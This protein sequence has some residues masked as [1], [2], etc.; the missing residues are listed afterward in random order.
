MPLFLSEYF[1]N[2]RCPKERPLKASEQF[3]RPTHVFQSHVLDCFHSEDVPCNRAEYLR[4]VCWLKE[5]GWIGNFHQVALNIV[6]FGHQFSYAR[7]HRS[8]FGPCANRRFRGYPTRGIFN[9]EPGGW[10][11]A[12]EAKK[13]FWTG[14]VVSVNKL[15]IPFTHS[16]SSLLINR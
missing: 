7:F 3:A 5:R 2:T 15:V 9:R 12:E 10:F 4:H 16:N 1:S 14:L 11:Q 13:I 6:C 8:E